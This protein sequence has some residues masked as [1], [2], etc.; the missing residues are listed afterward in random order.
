M[1]TVSTATYFDSKGGRHVDD[2]PKAKF[3]AM[4]AKDGAKENPTKTEFATPVEALL[5]AT[6]AHAANARGNSFGVN[7]FPDLATTHTRYLPQQEPTASSL[8][9]GRTAR[10][11]SRTTRPA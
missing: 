6:Q 1:G 5:G 11:A 8:S 9:D 4:I 3:Q 10:T 7:N 2:L